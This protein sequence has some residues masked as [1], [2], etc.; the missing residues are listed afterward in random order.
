MI[1]ITALQT[2]L[3][4]KNPRVILRKALE[5]FDNIAISFSGAEDVVLIDMALAI[6]K[7][8]QV[9]PW[10]Q[11]ACTLKPTAIWKKSAHI[12]ASTSNY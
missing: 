8:I 3:A 6:R 9:F 10:T 12:T 4:G 5:S 7:D 1:D 11:D 2:E